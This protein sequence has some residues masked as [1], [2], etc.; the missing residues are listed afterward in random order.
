MCHFAVG[1]EKKKGKM[2]QVGYISAVWWTDPVEKIS[3]KTEKV[4]WVHDVIIQFNFGSNIFGGFRPTRGQHFRFP[5]DYVCNRYN[6]AATT[7]QPV[8]YKI[9]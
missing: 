6:S 5:I 2:L 3:T 1:K 4:V 9:T 8:M 7:P